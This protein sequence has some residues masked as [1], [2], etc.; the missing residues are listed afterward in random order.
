MGCTFG[1]QLFVER[2]FEPSVVSQSRYSSRIEDSRHPSRSSLP[3]F[4]VKGPNRLLT[5]DRDFEKGRQLHVSRARSH[6][7]PLRGELKPQKHLSQMKYMKSPKSTGRISPNLVFSGRKKSE[8]DPS[9]RVDSRRSSPVKGPGSKSASARR[10]TPSTESF[11]SSDE[12]LEITSLNQWR[13]GQLLGHNSRSHIISANSSRR[14]GKRASVKSVGSLLSRTASRRWEASMLSEATG[15]LLSET[16][17]RRWEFSSD[18]SES[19]LAS[20]AYLHDMSETAKKRWESSSDY[21]NDQDSARSSKRRW[22][23]YSSDEESK[24]TLSHSTYRARFEKSADSLSQLQSSLREPSRSKASRVVSFGPS[25]NSQC[26]SRGDSHG[27]SA[28]SESKSAQSSHKGSSSLSKHLPK[29]RTSLGLEANAKVS[30]SLFNQTPL[31]VNVIEA[32]K[33]SAALS[34]E[35]T[36][37]NNNLEFEDIRRNLKP[38]LTSRQHQRSPKAGSKTTKT[39]GIGELRPAML[40]R[41]K[42]KTMRTLG[43][44]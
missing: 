2:D 9:T 43:L 31:L 17:Q 7:G 22:Q 25:T 36:S 24:D 38:N 1:S 44:K 20:A 27:G 30:V 6:T 37:S 26:S 4:E 32:L 15:S 11:W 39:T 13:K 33:E 42:L 18:E 34:G 12:P 14:S 29:S 3:R 16:V 41:E 21:I 5:T 40:I 8:N 28:L 19:E 35:D 10:G 23:E